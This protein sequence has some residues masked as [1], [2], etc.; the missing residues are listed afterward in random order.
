LTISPFEG[1]L[2]WANALLFNSILLEAGP[3]LTAKAVEAGIVRQSAV[4]R[5]GE[6]VSADP[7]LMTNPFDS[8]AKLASLAHA[9]GASFTLWNH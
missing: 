5:T 1:F 3:T 2:E 9:A 6:S 4:T 8:Q 7:M